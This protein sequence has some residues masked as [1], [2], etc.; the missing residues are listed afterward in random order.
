MLVE[1]LI[2]A[3]I[4]NRHKNMYKV[5]D[6]CCIDWSWWVR[7]ICTLMSVIDKDNRIVV[8]IVIIWLVYAYVVDVWYIW[9]NV[10]VKE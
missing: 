4:D 9:C 3:L 8:N 10:I 7:I 5:F 2:N 6:M 1:C